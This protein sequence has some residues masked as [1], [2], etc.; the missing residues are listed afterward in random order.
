MTPA[1]RLQQRLT[2]RMREALDEDSDGLRREISG[3]QVRIN[4]GLKL[5]HVQIDLDLMCSTMSAADEAEAAG[6]RSTAESLRK[7]VSNLQKKIADEF[8]RHL[9][10]TPGRG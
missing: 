9:A 7:D 6:A 10:L 2:Q 8:A 5:P 3:I 1:H 4:E